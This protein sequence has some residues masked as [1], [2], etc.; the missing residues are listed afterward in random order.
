LDSYDKGG[1]EDVETE[2]TNILQTYTVIAIGFVLGVLSCACVCVYV[3]RR[4]AKTNIVQ[5][6]LKVVIDIPQ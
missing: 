4:K 5:S 6:E 2:N 1:E 3:M